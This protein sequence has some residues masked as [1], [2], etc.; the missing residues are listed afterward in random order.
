MLAAHNIHV[1]L[2]GRTILHDVSLRV[3]AGQLAAIIGANGS[4]KS[5]LLKAMTGDLAHDGTVTLH[6]RPLESYRPHELARMRAVLAQASQVAFPFTVREIVSL[7]G[8]SR[9][10]RERAQDAIAR[11]LQEVGLAGFEGRFYADLSGGEQQR[12]QLARVRNQVWSAAHEGRAN[13]LFLDEPVSSL[14]V[15]HQLAIMQIARNFAD[16][17]GVVVAIIHDINLTAAF[18][19]R[20]LSLRQGQV[21][22]SG[23]CRAVLTDPVLR[24][25]YDCPLKVNTIPEKCSTFVLP[26]ASLDCVGKATSMT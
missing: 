18:A 6:G 21:V 10:G 7:G 11:A 25:T 3:E 26:H 20:V 2:S 15:K 19:D 16:R 17:G 22:A 23:T 24:R 13:F 8:L 14:D 12:V 5:T 4:G 9:P 1:R